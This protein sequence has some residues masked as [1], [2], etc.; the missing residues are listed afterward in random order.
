MKLFCTSCAG[1]VSD[2]SHACEKFEPAKIEQGTPSWLA[3]RMG[4]IGSSDADIV[5]ENSPWMSKR[6]LWELKTGRRKPEP[7]N[8]AMQRGLDL[9][10]LA[11]EAYERQTGILMPKTIAKHPQYDF[12]RTSLDGSNKSAGKALEIKCPGSKDHATAVK[13]EIPQKYIWQ[14]VHH[15]MVTGLSKLDYFSF[16]GERGITVPMKR[17]LKLEKVLLA[18]EI[19]FW[20]YVVSDKYPSPENGWTFPTRKRSK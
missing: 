17:D 19:K 3:W 14:C 7:R 1:V 16:D 9:E 6:Q 4:G 15:M 8:F 2:A 10:P 11:R 5:M 20:G 13:G 18:E 12:L